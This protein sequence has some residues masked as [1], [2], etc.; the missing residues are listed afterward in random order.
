MLMPQTG[1][2]QFLTYMNLREVS[3]GH[4]QFARI[5]YREAE[6]CVSTFITVKGRTST[7]SDTCLT[8]SQFALDKACSDDDT[9]S[10]FPLEVLKGLKGANGSLSQ[11]V[12]MKNGSVSTTVHTRALMCQYMKYEK[13]VLEQRR[14]A[15]D[16]GLKEKVALILAASKGLGRASAAALAAEGADIVIG[17]RNRDALE[18]TAQELTVDSG[19]HVL[20]VP[21]DVTK[22]EEIE[23]IVATTVRG[24]WSY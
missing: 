13:Y 3:N 7:I 8:S 5:R 23:A 18:K 20:A 14:R 12:S 9:I 19:G 17:A 22:E 4:D 1:K 24:V 15:M 16:L 21:T 6:H 10:P 2:A 11:Q